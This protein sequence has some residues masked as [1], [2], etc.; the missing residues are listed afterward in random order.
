MAT[1]TFATSEDRDSEIRQRCGCK[2]L[3]SYA[4]N[5][6]APSSKSRRHVEDVHNVGVEAAV[7]CARHEICTRN[8]QTN[9]RPLKHPIPRRA[10]HNSQRCDNQHGNTVSRTKASSSED[11]DSE[12]RQRCGCKIKSSYAESCSAPSSRRHVEDV[13]NVGGG[14]GGRCARHETCTCNQQTNLRP[15]KHPIPQPAQ[16]NTQ[17]Y[18]I[19]MATRTFATSEDRD[20]NIRQRCGCKITSSYAESCSAPSS[21]RHV[22]DVHNVQVAAAACCARHETCT[23]NQQTNLRPLKHPIPQPAQHNKQRYEINMAT[24]TFATSEDRDSNI[25]QR[26]GCKI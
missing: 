19:N 26:C 4:E 9:L 15:L 17:R 18:K 8:Q 20:S 16:H 22:E 13:H 12:I 11:R 2:I 21:R 3:S 1:R 6:S 24:R 23:R 25:R 14:V 10:Q 5:C 7:R